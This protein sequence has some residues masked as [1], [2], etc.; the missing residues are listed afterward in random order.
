MD[1]KSV[2]AKALGIICII[3]ALICLTA[4]ASGIAALFELGAP[5]WLASKYGVVAIST[6]IGFAA[7]TVFFVVAARRYFQK[8][9]RRATIMLLAGCIIAGAAIGTLEAMKKMADAKRA[10]TTMD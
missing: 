1:I 4:L 8:L 5:G 3:G 9:W 7:G 2:I 6:L 10:H